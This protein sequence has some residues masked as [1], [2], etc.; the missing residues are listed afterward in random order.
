MNGRKRHLLV[1]P[2]GLLRQV[3]VHTADVLDRDEARLLL[4]G[5][6]A[7]HP[8][9]AHRW[10]DAGDRGTC[11]TWIEQTLGW[12]VAVVRKP[13]RW[14]W[15]PEGVAPPPMPAWFPVRKRRWVVERT[16]PGWAA[17]DD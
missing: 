7:A 5:Q 16:L 9:L 15:Y 11:V 17:I 3:V 4:A 2:T 10:I 1:D 12:T 8:R 6:A 13:G 14:G